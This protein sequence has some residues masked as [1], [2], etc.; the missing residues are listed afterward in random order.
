MR[1]R[2][3]R[4]AEDAEDVISKRLQNAIEEISHWKE[5]DYVVVNEDL[6]EAFHQVQSILT[7][8]RLRRDR[9]PGL[10]EFEDTLVNG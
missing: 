6:D 3:I 1:S 2:L 9:R 5:Y 8:E 10:F 4:R 7:A